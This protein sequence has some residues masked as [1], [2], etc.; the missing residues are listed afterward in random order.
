[1]RRRMRVAF[2]GLSITTRAVHRGAIGSNPMD[3][4]DRY[5]LGQSK[6]SQD[7]AQPNTD[8]AGN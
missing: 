2:M 8:I 4:G 6:A 3:G 5:R 7:K 1:M